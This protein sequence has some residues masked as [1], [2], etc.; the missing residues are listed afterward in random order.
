MR[1]AYNAANGSVFRLLRDEYEKYAPGF[2]V[3]F[4][5]VAIEGNKTLL[6]ALHD[7]PEQ[8][9]YDGEKFVEGGETDWLIDTKYDD[10]AGEFQVEI[11]TLQQ[12]LTAVDNIGSLSDA[13]PVLVKMVRAIYALARRVGIDS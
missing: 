8:F 9:V 3:A 12:A 10:S 4:V 5:D 7:R 6:L 2:T 13:K 11:P 1:V